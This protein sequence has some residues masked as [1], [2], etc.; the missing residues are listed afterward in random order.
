MR[1]KQ[2]H[3]LPVRL[4]QGDISEASTDA[5]AN[6]ANNH[7]WMGAGLAGAIK[8]KGG[9]EIERAA[10]AKEPIPV[11]EAV[12]S[13]AGRLKTR[14]VIHAAAMGQD[15]ETDE[16]K[17]RSAT[18]NSL[19]RAE[20]L[21][22]ASIAFPALGTRVGGLPAPDAARVM[23]R[24]LSEHASTAGSLREVSFSF[25]MPPPWLPLRWAS[26]GYLE[27]CSHAGRACTAR[28][29]ISVMKGSPGESPPGR[30]G[31][32]LDHGQLPTVCG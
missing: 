19:K 28:A 15:L 16:A 4:L 23:L 24:A 1:E 7:L 21:G 6:A 22:R 26:T 29:A 32:G 5:I 27:R 25:L 13:G 31:S 10:V 14:Y 2:I 8:R 30:T 3:R 17:I 18:L 11:G 12:A 20:E 9:V